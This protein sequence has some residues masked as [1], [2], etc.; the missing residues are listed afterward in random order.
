MK[1]NFGLRAFEVAL[2]SHRVVRNSWNGVWLSLFGSLA[3]SKS[4]LTHWSREC[5]AW[6]E[7]KPYIHLNADCETVTWLKTRAGVLGVS[8]M[9]FN[10]GAVIGF[11]QLKQIIS[12]LNDLRCIYEHPGPSSSPLPFLRKNKNKEELH[13]LNSWAGKFLLFCHCWSSSSILS[14]WLS[15]DHR[16]A[17]FIPV[18][19]CCLERHT[20]PQWHHSHSLFVCRHHAWLAASLTLIWANEIFRL[21]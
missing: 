4:I 21:S 6:R 5:N 3:Q 7:A 2:A 14:S 18:R 11:Y 8:Q 12:R 17:K 13:L 15:S 10:C 9:W 16:G 20:E 19:K 1:C